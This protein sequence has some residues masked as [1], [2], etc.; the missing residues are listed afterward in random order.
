[1][2][3]DTGQ[4]IA[5]ELTSKD[6]DDG[7]QVGPLLRTSPSFTGSATSL[8]LVHC[9]I[10]GGASL[11]KVRAQS[12]S[13][14]PGSKV[15]WSIGPMCFTSVPTLISWPSKVALGLAWRNP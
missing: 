8:N 11:P 7:S 6:V 3:A 9:S 4:I 15:L 14:M 1:M 10:F 2:D 5:A 12:T 13:E